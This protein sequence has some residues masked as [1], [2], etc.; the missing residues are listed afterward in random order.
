MP[1]SVATK[2]LATEND[3]CTSVRL[4]AVGV[5]LVQQTVAVQHDERRRVGALQYLGERNALVADVVGD[6]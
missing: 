1:T 5:A 4:G 3:V 2:D 6:R